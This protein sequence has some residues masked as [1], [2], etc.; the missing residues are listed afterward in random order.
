MAIHHEA[1]I[2]DEPLGNHMGFGLSYLR[3][4]DSLLKKVV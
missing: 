4:G 3:K 1:S 2:E